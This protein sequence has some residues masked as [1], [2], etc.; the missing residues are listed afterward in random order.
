L[1]LGR[2]RTVVTLASSLEINVLQVVCVFRC[3]YYTSLLLL[4]I[5]P[6]HIVTRIHCMHIRVPQELAGSLYPYLSI[7][8]VRVPFLGIAMD[9]TAGYTEYRPPRHF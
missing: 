5:L 1:L 8:Y 4:D 7:L 9:L 2:V 3:T 6:V